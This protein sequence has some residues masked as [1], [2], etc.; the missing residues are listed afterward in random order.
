MRNYINIC[1]EMSSFDTWF[2]GS[3][4]VDFDGN[5]LMVY[6]GTTSS[7]DKFEPGHENGMTRSRTGYYF[8]DDYDAAAE[9]GPVR[10]FFLSLKNPANFEEERDQRI[11]KNVLN[12]DPKFWS[13]IP[14]YF[15]NK[16]GDTDINYY[17]MSANGYLQLP[18]FIHGLV[19]LGYDGMIMEDA[20]FGHVF[21]SYI[22]FDAGSIWEYDYD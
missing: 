17:R 11:I 22:A 10:S 16:Y 9:F 3:K 7:F 1:E 2:S 19:K 4:I 14:K 5:P 8:T 20:C 21:T 12:I 15:L 13:D 6:H 18:Q